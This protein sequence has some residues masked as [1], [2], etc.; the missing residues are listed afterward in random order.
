MAYELIGALEDARCSRT[1]RNHDVEVLREDAIEFL[2]TVR[3]SPLT[4]QVG[5]VILQMLQ[6]D[7]WT[8]Y[9]T[10]IRGLMQTPSRLGSV[11]DLLGKGTSAA[12]WFREFG[13]TIT[14][15]VDA[16]AQSCVSELADCDEDEAA[17]AVR[18]FATTLALSGHIPITVYAVAISNASIH[19]ALRSHLPLSG[20]NSETRN[21]CQECRKLR[22]RLLLAQ[23]RIA[24]LERTRPTGKPAFAE[25]ER[26]TKLAR[27][28]L[29]R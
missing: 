29:R 10:S 20:T 21:E 19:A 3:L 12:F 5:T 23:H 27:R 8:Q 26:F 22:V 24:E 17:A 6:Q 1:F 2:A 25:A 16:F 9:A 11:R 4:L 13:E 28:T 18:S 15:S 7:V 14:V